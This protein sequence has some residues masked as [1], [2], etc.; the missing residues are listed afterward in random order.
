MGPGKLSSPVTTL[1]NRS[2]PASRWFSGVRMRQHTSRWFS[3]GRMRHQDDGRARRLLG[4]KTSSREHCPDFDLV[5]TSWMVVVCET[6]AAMCTMCWLG[7]SPA[8]CT[9]IRIII[10][11]SD[12]SDC[13]SLLSSRSMFVILDGWF[14]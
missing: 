6:H 4:V 7:S 11:L 10:T 1:L 5:G 13:L 3:G 2:R 14:R 12:L 9:P 8:G